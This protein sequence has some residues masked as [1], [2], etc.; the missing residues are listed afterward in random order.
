MLYGL[1]T[2]NVHVLCSF[3]VVYFCC[4]LYTSS[5]PDDEPIESHPSLC[6]LLFESQSPQL[7]STV[8]SGRRV[9]PDYEEMTS[10]LDW[11]ATGYCIAHSDTTSSWSV[12]FG[13]GDITTPSPQCLQAFSSG[14]HYS[15]TTTHRSGGT[16]SLT[17]LTLE[18]D[19][20]TPVSPYLETF[21]SLFPY[22]QAITVLQ[23]YGDLC[24]DDRGVPVL[25]QL[26]HYC[27]RLRELILPTLHPPYL[28][29]VPQLPQHTLDTLDLMLPLMKDDSILGHHLQQCLALKHLILWGAEDKLVMMIHSLY[30]DTPILLISGF[31]EQ[32]AIF[33]GCVGSKGIS[34]YLWINP[35]NTL[36][37]FRKSNRVSEFK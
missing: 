24:S 4:V 19:L 28:S 30:D 34:V 33:R 27:P 22:S 14:L 21:P 1:V 29:L 26:S 3:S 20:E 37:T 23:L 5:S 31:F 10:P 25:Q 6:Q 15:S 18:T 17:E 11:F 8:F 16:G 13:D 7:V 32:C 12:E 36:I 2:L 35:R 9:Q